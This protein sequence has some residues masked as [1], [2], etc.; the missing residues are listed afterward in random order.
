MRGL[1]T[2]NTKEKYCFQ[3]AIPFLLCFAIVGV[4]GGKVRGGGRRVVVGC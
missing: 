3:F 1:D 2:L 4:D